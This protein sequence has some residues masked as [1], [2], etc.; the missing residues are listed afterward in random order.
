MELWTS[1]QLRE[2]FLVFFKRKGHKIFPSSSLTNSGDPSVL[3]T[4]AGMQQF[5]PFYLDPSKADK[6]M[7]GRNAASSQKCF[8][9]T[10]IDEVGDETHNTFFEMLGNFSFG[11]YFKKEAIE[12]AFE[13]LHTRYK[14]QDTRYKITVF[15]GDKKIPRDEESVKIWAKLGFSEKKGNL[16][17]AGREDNFWGPTGAK[18]PCGPT[19]EIYVDGVEIWNIVFNEYYCEKSEDGGEKLEKLK[20]PGVDTGMGLERLTRV[21]QGAPSIFEIDLFAPLIKEV[22]TYR[23]AQNQPQGLVMKASRIIADHMRGATFLMAE[24]LE[25]SNV[26]AGYVLR[27]ILRRAIRFAHTIKLPYEHIRSLIPLTGALYQEIYPELIQN[28]KNIFQI[29]EKE[30]HSFGKTI[31]NGMNVFEKTI[32]KIRKSVFPGEQA[33]FLYATYG[34]PLELIEEMLKERNINLDKEGFSKA[35]QIHRETSKQTNP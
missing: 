12:L 19:T 3:L 32:S 2:E 17:F 34:F 5:K 15:G 16:Q 7:G 18:G 29:F 25:P 23:Q 14:I 27:R 22:V 13:L 35:L 28:Q 8:R 4:T 11:G 33:F 20:A 9:T 10:D 31:K 30:Y 1:N 24:G 26:K 21:I 6:E